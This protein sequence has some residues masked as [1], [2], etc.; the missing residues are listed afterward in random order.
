MQGRQFIGMCLV[1]LCASALAGSPESAMERYFPQDVLAPQGPLRNKAPLPGGDA[2]RRPGSPAVRDFSLACQGLESTAQKG[3][4]QAQLKLGNCLE[5][6]NGAARNLPLALHWY[7]QAA[8]QGLPDAQRLLGILYLN[9]TQGPGHEG[10]GL[11][12]LRQAVTQ[13]DGFA[14][15]LLASY[16][17][18]YE[19]RTTEAVRSCHH[20]ALALWDDGR[21]DAGSVAAAVQG[22]CAAEME[23]WIQVHFPEWAAHALHSLSR[24]AQ[25]AERGDVLAQVA[26][27]RT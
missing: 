1:A 15:S 17:G 27:F 25:E 4:A 26:K 13:G 8:M 11:A 6:G 14:K 24:G 7:E 23:A 21:S 3:D 5:N 22:A 20:K 16:A 10:R 12:W 18:I 2:L 19:A 9:G